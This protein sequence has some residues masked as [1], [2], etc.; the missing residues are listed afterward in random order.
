VTRAVVA[1]GLGPPATDAPW[2]GAGWG[3]R[4]DAPVGSA[5]P[6]WGWCLLA[7]KVGT[8]GGEGGR[9]LTQPTSG[10]RAVR[11][12]TALPTQPGSPPQ[13]DTSRWNGRSTFAVPSLLRTITR[14]ANMSSADPVGE[15]R[16]ADLADL[17]RVEPVRWGRVM[18]SL[19]PIGKAGRG[20][21][22]PRRAPPA[23][24][25]Q[26]RLQAR[27]LGARPRARLPPG[28]FGFPERKTRPRTIA[29]GRHRTEKWENVL[30]GGRK[31]GTVAP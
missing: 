24:L 9:I 2:A 13:Q 1:L 5:Q 30:L 21:A 18:P 6:S 12:A 28:P 3:Q 25:V 17:G 8:Q 26:R 4:P 15:R 10:R 23:S 14:T 11:A 19:E 27:A 22:R 31:W 7:T 16:G 29:V 20:G